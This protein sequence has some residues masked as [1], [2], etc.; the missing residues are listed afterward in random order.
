MYILLGP[1]TQPGF[2]MTSLATGGR[3]LVTTA[4]PE[5]LEPLD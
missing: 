4:P 2:D 1:R 5:K 3:D